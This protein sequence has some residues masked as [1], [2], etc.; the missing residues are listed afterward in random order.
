MPSEGRGMANEGGEREDRRVC[1]G[2][3]KGEGDRRGERGQGGVRGL[4]GR[5][6]ENERAGGWR[7]AS[8]RENFKQ[9]VGR[10]LLRHLMVADS[11][12]RQMR[13]VEDALLGH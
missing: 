2:G 8:C 3:Q 13:E 5:G 11:H 4:G 6:R 12:D 1:V 7:T 10:T 9:L